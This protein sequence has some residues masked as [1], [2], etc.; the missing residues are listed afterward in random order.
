MRRAAT[1]RPTSSTP[2]GGRTRWMPR[3]CAS[4]GHGPSAAPM[5]STRSGTAWASPRR[6]AERRRGGA[7]RP[8]RSG[9]SSPWSPIACSP[10][11]PSWRRLEWAEQDVA[12]AGVDRLG[13]DPQIF[14]RAMDF[15]READE[16]IQREVFF[17]VANLFNLEVDVLLFDTTST[18]FETEDDEDI[19]PSGPSN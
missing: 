5:S 10:P 17:A 15:L 11:H 6:S 18:Y 1:S 4:S 8:R 16:A 2:W 12:R 19:P 7:S 14:Y 13:A 9:S 3:C